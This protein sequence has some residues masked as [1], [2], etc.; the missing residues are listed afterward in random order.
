MSHRHDDPAYRAARSALRRWARN[1]G[2][3][4]AR[5]GLPIDYDA[6]WLDPRSFTAGHVVALAHGGDNDPSNLRPEHRRCNL[7]H[8]AGTRRRPADR[9]ADSPGRTPS[10][11]W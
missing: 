7:R 11:E 1:T 6:G 4:C 2:A 10:R 9:P 8:G 3:E 5:C